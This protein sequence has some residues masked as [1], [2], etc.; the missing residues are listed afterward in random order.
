MGEEVWQAVVLQTHGPPA[1]VI[2]PWGTLLVAGFQDGALKIS[3]ITLH[4]PD[5]LLDQTHVFTSEGALQ[6]T[7]IGH[8]RPI[9]ALG[10]DNVRLISAAQDGALRAWT[11]DGQ[12]LRVVPFGDAPI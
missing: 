11:I 4:A 7:L 1:T 12:C 8:Q 5:V 2:I 10:V 9:T 3:I 6:G